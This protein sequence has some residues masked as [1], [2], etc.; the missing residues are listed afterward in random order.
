MYAP[1][2]MITASK[3]NTKKLQGVLNRGLRYAH[4]ERYPYTRNTRTLHEIS[5]IEPINY[6]L[7]MQANKIFDKLRVL[8]DEHFSTLLD[9]YEEERNHSWFRKTKNILERGIPEKIYTV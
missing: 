3:T 4:N 2:P 7:H 6:S 1:I 8:G 5:N 9:N